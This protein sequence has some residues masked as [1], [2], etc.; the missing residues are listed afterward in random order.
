MFSNYC[1]NDIEN[2]TL[3][4][5]GLNDIIRDIHYLKFSKAER[6]DQ[7]ILCCDENENIYVF[8][9]GGIGTGGNFIYTK[10]GGDTYISNCS[11]Y[12]VYMVWPEVCESYEKLK[13]PKDVID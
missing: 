10:D 3:L 6:L 9:G 2:E 7:F 8:V 5:E 4:R 12:H 13:R 1:K 11:S